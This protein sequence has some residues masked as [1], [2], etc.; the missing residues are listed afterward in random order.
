MLRH[1]GQMPGWLRRLH[2]TV[3]SPDTPTYVRHFLV[4]MI[5]HVDKRAVAAAALDGQT[6]CPTSLLCVCACIHSY[7]TAPTRFRPPF[8]PPL[9]L[10]LP[11]CVRVSVRI[12]LCMHGGSTCAVGPHVCRSTWMRERV[13]WLSMLSQKFFLI[14]SLLRRLRGQGPFPAQYRPWHL[15]PFGKEK[16]AD[17]SQPVLNA[18]TRRVR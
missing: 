10:P 9:S 6:V 16:P 3:Q 1:T 8:S 17:R 14:L 11:V 2:T 18:F 13:L 5:L 4:R 12:C 7:T 15:Q